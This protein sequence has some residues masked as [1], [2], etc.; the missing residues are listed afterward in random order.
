MGRRVILRSSAPPLGD[1]DSI[2]QHG[3]VVDTQR[4]EIEAEAELPDG[5]TPNHQECAKRNAKEHSAWPLRILLGYG[6]IRAE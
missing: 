3:Y 5:V 6:D 2:D 4:Y 1:C